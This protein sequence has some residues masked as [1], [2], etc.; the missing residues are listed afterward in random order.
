MT[1]RL[2]LQ[3]YYKT[4]IHDW[5]GMK[6]GPPGE[7]HF[8]GCYLLPLLLAETDLGHPEY[9][10]LDGSKNDILPKIFGDLAWQTN[11]GDQYGKQIEVKIKYERSLIFRNFTSAQKT[12]IDQKV[13]KDNAYVLV[14]P[15]GVLICSAQKILETLEKD[16]LRS[17]KWKNIRNYY[18]VDFSQEEKLFIPFDEY[19][20]DKIIKAIKKLGVH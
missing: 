2:T 13:E 3:E 1:K 7:H 18:S 19:A 16:S 10:N 11:F 15:Y 8:V 12:H 20:D 17:Q 6:K 4:Y 9:L 5:V 14:A